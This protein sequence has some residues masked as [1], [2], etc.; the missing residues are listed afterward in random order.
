MMR[1]TFVTLLLLGVSA[2][3]AERSGEYVGSYSSTEGEA[4]GKLRIVILKDGDTAWTC[5]VFFTTAG[6]DTEIE[7]KPGKCSVDDHSIS[8]EFDAATEGSS[9]HATIKGTATDDKSFEG[10]YTTASKDGESDD[11][12][13]WHASLRP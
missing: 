6:G 9:F 1:V 11:R 7:T 12:G 13:K 5:K 3:A 8:N 2:F 10:T 4:T